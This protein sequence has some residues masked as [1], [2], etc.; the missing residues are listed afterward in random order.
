M[1]VAAGGGFRHNLEQLTQL[2]DSQ[3][4]LARMTVRVLRLNGAPIGALIMGAHRRLWD[5]MHS[6]MDGEAPGDAEPSLNFTNFM[7]AALSVAKIH[8]LVVDPDQQGR[9]HGTRLLRSALDTATRDKLIMAYGQFAA[10]RTPLVSFYQRAGFEVLDPG[11]PL[12]LSAVTGND[13]D[14]MTGLDSERFFVRH[15]KIT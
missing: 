11:E 6:R 12:S 15:Q 14:A 10:E 2:P 7:I 3:W 9:G 8:T 4:G 1:G 13:A 5:V